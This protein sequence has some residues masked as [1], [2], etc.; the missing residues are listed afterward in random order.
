MHRS[1]YIRTRFQNLPKADMDK[2]KEY[3]KNPKVKAIGEI[4]LDYFMIFHRVIFS[5]S[6]LQ[7]KWTLHESLK[8][9]L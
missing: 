2:L 9:L 7:D 5:K 1:E 6:G 8:C 4:G 3:A